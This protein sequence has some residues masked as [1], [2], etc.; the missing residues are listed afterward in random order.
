MLL[1]TTTA[2]ERAWR[3]TLGNFGRATLTRL[4]LEFGTFYTLPARRDVM[5]IFSIFGSFFLA[6]LLV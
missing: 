5:T 6:F 2:R 4:A 1:L 3:F